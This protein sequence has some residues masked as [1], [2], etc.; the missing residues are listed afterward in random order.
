MKNI[1]GNET[2]MSDSVNH[3]AHYTS[4]GVERMTH[5]EVKQILHLS[6]GAGYD[7]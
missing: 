6:R 4:G 3:P 5:E 1:S 2:T 7:D